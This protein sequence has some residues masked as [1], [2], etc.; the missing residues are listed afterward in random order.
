MAAVTMEH[1]L[2]H[3]LEVYDGD[4]R[5]FVC[6]GRWLHPLFDL[7]RF[8]S[9]SPIVPARLRAADRIVG[10]AA[11]MILVHL[12]LGAVYGDTMSRLAARFLGERGIPHAHRILVDEI[13]CRTESLLLDED[14][15]AKAYDLVLERARARA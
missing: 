12:G 10:K 14:D 6:D 7:E 2:E 15:P 11:A 3:S 5:V 8:L 9:S 4:R 1:R 13:A